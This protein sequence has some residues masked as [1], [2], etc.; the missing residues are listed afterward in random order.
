MAAITASNVLA[1]A[2]NWDNYFEKASMGSDS[3][4]KNKS[5]NPGYANITWFWV[6]LERLGYGNLQEEPWCDGFVDFCF[7]VCAGANSAGFARA[8]KALGGFSAYTPTSAQ[9]FKDLGPGHWIPADGNPL[10][11]DQIFFKDSTGEICHTGLVTRVTAATVYTI[12]GN[13]SSA[14]G[15]VANGGCTRQKSYDRSYSRIAGYGRALWESDEN[16]PLS[17]SSVPEQVYNWG[18]D[19]GYSPEAICGIMGNMKQESDM[20]PTC[21][22]SP[23]PYAAGICQWERYNTNTGR[24]KMLST[25][26][27][28]RGKT[29]KDLLCQLN[30]LDKEL[31]GED[32]EYG[33][34]GYTATLVRKYAGSF[35][36]FKACTDVKNAV[37]IFH[38]AFERSSIPN[39]PVRYSAAESFYKKYATG[40]SS[41]S[42]SSGGTILRM[43][44][45]G[46]EVKK[47]QQALLS[48]GYDLGDYGADGDFGES[49]YEALKEF[50]AYH[51]LEVDGE[52]GPASRAI[53]EKPFNRDYLQSG[54]SGESVRTM[55]LLLL[56]AGYSVGSAGADGDFGA[57]S[58]AALKKY[59]ADAGLTVTGK[60]DNTTKQK[61]ND[62]VTKI[63][64]GSTNSGTTTAKPAED[65]KP[66][67]NTTPTYTAKIYKY[68]MTNGTIKAYQKI[69][70]DK[71]KYDIVPSGTFGE[72]TLETVVHFQT[73]HGLTAN[74]QLNKETMAKIKNEEYHEIPDNYISRYQ[75]MMNVT[76]NAKLD[77]TGKWN[78]PTGQSVSTMKRGDSGSL[79]RL[80]QEILVKKIKRELT[81]SGAYDAK[82]E[83]AIKFVQE[84]YGL[85]ENGT[86]T[87]PV[88]NVLLCCDYPVKS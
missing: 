11:G 79:V 71:W 83:E 56:K 9:M 59:Q 75:Y 44:S 31:S 88:W 54:D 17:G 22:Q 6:Q 65:T 20:D 28:S 58:E 70:H 24:F 81:I 73:Y 78:E 4:L 13:T 18:I 5:W 60:Y 41:S 42:G 82:T 68:G 3:Q 29:W 37:K 1:V 85:E 10:P 33:G 77:I 50:Q 23:T 72:A 49:T 61:L 74:G 21:L 27:K 19:H 76:Y 52:Y 38:D 47:M 16:A 8:K 40:T 62:K 66:S 12:E 53:L 51:N 2:L 84:Y 39:W 34:D 80:L 26:A 86:V 36:K 43:G 48:R 15:V 14:S 7:I 30:W 55:Q 57:G 32:V 45:S 25:Y 35:A 69:L 64:S 87:R 63:E 67:Q 46:P